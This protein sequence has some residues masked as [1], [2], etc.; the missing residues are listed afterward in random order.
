MSIIDNIVDNIFVLDYIA[1]ILILL[2]VTILFIRKKINKNAWVLYW[3]GVGLG[4]IWEIPIGL[5][6]EMG[7]PIAEFIKPRPV[8]PFPLHSIMHSIWD[9][10]IFLVGIFLVYKILSSPHFK[11]FNKS[12]LLI[13][14]V[15]GQLQ[16]VILEI[17]SLVIGLWNYIPSWW[18]P[19]MF[20]IKGHYF[21]LFPQ[22]VWL[23][24]SIIFYYLTL[25]FNPI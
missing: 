18:N 10:G 21:T 4:L 24:A 11:N 5:T 17:V 3:V 23:F 8:L 15:W 1:A 19:S 7:V 20:E 25:K 12:E 2:I 6:R 13:F 9:G 14:I 22:Y 16:S